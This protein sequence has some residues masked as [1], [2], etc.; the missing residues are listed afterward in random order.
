LLH[1]EPRKLGE[2]AFHT[3]P[4][5]SFGTSQHTKI[6][7][8]RLCH[9][10]AGKSHLACLEANYLKIRRKVPMV[11]IGLD[12]LVSPVFLPTASFP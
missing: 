6:K 9:M 2:N 1:N 10:R 4:R 5:W 12:H 8:T 3:L 11:L 7:N